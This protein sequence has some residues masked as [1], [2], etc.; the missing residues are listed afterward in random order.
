MIWYFNI[1][2]KISQSFHKRNIYGLKAF[3][4]NCKS[5]CTLRPCANKKMVI[6]LYYQNFS[7]DFDKTWSIYGKFY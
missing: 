7:T 3:K 2:E 6:N 5:F 4:G 1:I